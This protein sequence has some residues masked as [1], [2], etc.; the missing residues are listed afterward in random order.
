MTKTKPGGARST[1]HI[2]HK[3]TQSAFRAFDYAGEAGHPLNWYVVINLRDET[4][5]AAA[6]AFGKILHKFRDWLTN[7]RKTVLGC[8][9]PIY[10]YAFENPSGEHVHVNWV[11]HIPP[12]WEREFDKKLRG[13]IRKVQG[14]A[15]PYDLSIQ[16]INQRYAKKLAKYVLKGTDP[17]YVDHFHLRDEHKPQGEVWG[18]R[19]GISQA[20]GRKARKKAGFHPGKRSYR[21]AGSATEKAG[22]VVDEAAI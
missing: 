20:I 5:Q 8:P 16:P 10:V 18:K 9:G 11:V 12:G 15:E 6:T 19:A 3:V 13:W 7:K 1:H 17:R 4:A 14:P 22:H 21:P 2:N